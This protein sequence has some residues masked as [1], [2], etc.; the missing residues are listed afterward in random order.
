[1]FVLR[2][3]FI[4]LFINVSMSGCKT[5]RTTPTSTLSVD[6]ERRPVLIEN[7]AISY[8]DKAYGGGEISDVESYRDAI[9]KI[10]NDDPRA[11]EGNYTKA[12]LRDYIKLLELYG[13][14][15][16]NRK[17][18]SFDKLSGMISVDGYVDETLGQEGLSGEEKAD[19]LVEKMEAAGSELEELIFGLTWKNLLKMRIKG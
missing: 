6:G 17:R 18:P 13:K 19:F 15:T 11:G 7:P 5:A 14:P 9:R 8:S 2:W 16:S 3:L 10:E 12:V 1:M 4:V